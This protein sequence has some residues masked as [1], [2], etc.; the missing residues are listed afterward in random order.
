TDGL[1]TMHLLNL[2]T[3]RYTKWKNKCKTLKNDLLLADIQ[4]DN[5]WAVQL[6]A[7]LR[8]GAVGQAENIVIP[9]HTVFDK[10]W[11][12]ADGCPTDRLP[13]PPNANTGNSVVV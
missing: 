5:K 7:N 2:T 6:D 10:V 13:N 9:A 4:L 3:K 1:I 8:H 12:F 11:S